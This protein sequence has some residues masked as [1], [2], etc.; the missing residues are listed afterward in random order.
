M[1]Y[2][3][4]FK[5]NLLGNRLHI[6]PF[7][8]VG[9]VWLALSGAIASAQPIRFYDT[10]NPLNSSRNL[11]PT[12][13]TQSVNPVEMVDV[14]LMP[15][16]D[17]QAVEEEDLARDAQGLP[18]RFAIANNVFLTPQNSGTW[19]Q[20]DRVTW[21][22]RLRL[23]CANAASINLGFTRYIMP[24]GG[25]LF[26]YATDG[27][28]E[29]RGFTAADNEAHGQLWT[30]PLNSDDIIIEVTLPSDALDQ[31]ELE[32]TRVN[33]GYRGFDKA[34]GD[35][36]AFSGSCNVDVACPE[37]NAWQSEIPGVALISIDGITFCT[38][39]LVNNTSQ[40]R[41]PYFMTANHCGLTAVNDASLIAFW[42][43]ENSICRPPGS[44]AS[45]TTGDG[46][47]FQHFNTGSIHRAGYVDSDFTLVEL[48]DNPDPLFG[49][50]FL[51]WN[52]SSSDPTSAVCIH[53]PAEEKRISFEDDPLITTSAGG[54][55]PQVG[56]T[57]LR[58]ID[59]DLGTTEFGSSGAPLFDQNHR[60]VGQL[61]GGDA[62]CDNAFSDWFGRF[63]VSWTGGGFSSSRLSN[64]LDPVSTGTMTLNTLTP[65]IDCDK[66]GLHDPEE[67]AA[68][69]ALD[70][71][72]DGVLN[73]CDLGSEVVEGFDSVS[74]LPLTDW[75]VV[76]NS[77]PLGPFSWGLG[78]PAAFA[79]Q[80]GSPDSYVAA[81]FDNTTD[82][83][84]I[85]NWFIT[86]EVDLIDGKVLSFYTRTS[87]GGLYP[88][89]LQ[90]RMSTNG[91]STN[92]GTTSLSVG[93]FTT[94][95]LNI[96]PLLLV[97]GYPESW[98]PAGFFQVTL[99]GIGPPTTG[100]FA[101]RYFVTGAGA[102]GVNS[103]FIGLDTVEYRSETNDTNSNG[104]P[105]SCE[106]APCPADFNSDTNVNVTDLLA[107]LAAWGTCLPPCPPDIN[108]DGFVNVTDLL[109]LL[110]AWGSCP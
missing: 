2:D 86:P 110:G 24:E 97:G 89:R 8:I 7:L 74:T 66:N 58:V 34:M 25:I 45:G 98:F 18:Y 91:S 11:E 51:G 63:S 67:I 60:V 13:K 93:D 20:L 6:S 12:A 62:A 27:S 42:N 79:A 68:N 35:K 78:N 21:L 3:T 4:D 31:L 46:I 92:V 22:W 100:R 36:S 49:V 90:V 99:S 69:P 16:I 85:S 55:V 43:Y 61:A 33:H 23:V 40:D 32:L 107:L 95:L 59:W 81:N 87:A 56:G 104:I 30:P 39:F 65:L 77:Q 102:L 5:A 50:T 109:A 88:D 41:T 84:T 15:G 29:I 72:T 103:F 75:M 10:A 44:P 76:N 57:H 101:F 28:S 70:C 47:L 38:G 105:D 94:L 82:N 80:A 108:S 83:G 9:L 37:G 71:N 106:S 14:R 54:F 48:D 19:E 26:V 17:L 64:W 73:V 96:N 1:Q 52:R 53:H